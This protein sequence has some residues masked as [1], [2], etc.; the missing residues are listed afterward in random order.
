MS[1]SCEVQRGM[2]ATCRS[3][4]RPT[5]EELTDRCRKEGEER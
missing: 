3:K 4:R 1:Q 2:E 5:E